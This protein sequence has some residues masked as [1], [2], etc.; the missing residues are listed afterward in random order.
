MVGLGSEVSVTEAHQRD[1]EEHEGDDDQ[2][3]EEE[4]QTGE[5]TVGDGELQEFGFG[6][7]HV[8]LGEHVTQRPGDARLVHLQQK[9]RTQHYKYNSLCFF[10]IFTSD[11]LPDATL[12]IYTSTITNTALLRASYQ[13][14]LHNIRYLK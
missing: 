14:H 12:P 13:R 10:L 1:D 4:E 5:E 8:G 2:G 7:D 3:G 9:Q 6:W 11:V